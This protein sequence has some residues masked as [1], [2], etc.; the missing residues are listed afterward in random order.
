MLLMS[1]HCSNSIKA[2]QNFI[3]YLITRTTHVFLCYG[4]SSS[5]VLTIQMTCMM[6]LHML[7]RGKGVAVPAPPH[8][9]QCGAQT[10]GS[11]LDFPSLQISN[12][13]TYPL[14]LFYFYVNKLN[15]AFQHEMC[16]KH[17]H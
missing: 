6:V 14:C 5:C 7:V 15:Y 12:H 17:S 10:F 9:H 3:P 16:P 1:L 11:S 4:K 13:H 2:W 8:P